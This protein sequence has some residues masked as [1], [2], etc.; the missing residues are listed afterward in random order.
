MPDLTAA[1]W[2]APHGDLCAA[3]LQELPIDG[4]AVS[5]FG[6]SAAE[7]LMC[8]SDATAGR[9]DELQYDLG[10]GPRWDVF[11]THL[12]VVIPDLTA[13]GVRSWP[14]FSEA[15]TRTEAAAFFVFPLLAGGLVI[16]V[17]ELYCTSPR[18]LSPAQVSRAAQ[19]ASR[20]AWTLLRG[21]LPGNE[22]GSAAIPLARREIHQ[23]T[24]MVLVQT[25]ST[26]DEA[27][28]LLR[29]H[30]FASGRS[31]QDTALDVV[32]RKLDFT[33]AAGAAETGSQ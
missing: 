16:G 23:A 7:T 17:A 24:G 27:L 5:V 8:A 3:F 33:P 4:A 6:G 28:L 30:A 18:E 12:P 22:A 25:D 11:R 19:I 13:E 15:A 20:T 1:P 26:A 2:N 10:D 29:G 32:S 31:L 14:A 21:L 9:L